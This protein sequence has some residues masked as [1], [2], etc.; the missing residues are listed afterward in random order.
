MVGQAYMSATLPETKRKIF[1]SFAVQN[2]ILA[3]SKLANK[4]REVGTYL[5]IYDQ[6]VTRAY[7]FISNKLVDQVYWRP[8]GQP[9]CGLFLFINKQSAV[10][11]YKRQARACQVG[12]CLLATSL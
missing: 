7:Q 1:L 2:L 11:L 4:G 10:P 9:S 3:T 6:T 12:T 5:F 8:V